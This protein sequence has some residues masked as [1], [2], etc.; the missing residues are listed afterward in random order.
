[1]DFKTLHKKY[2]EL[3]PENNKL[4]EEIK[5]V[6]TQLGMDVIHEE[7]ESSENKISECLNVAEPELFDRQTETTLSRMES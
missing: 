2:G 1:M 7:S 5:R 4:R 6:K 3:L